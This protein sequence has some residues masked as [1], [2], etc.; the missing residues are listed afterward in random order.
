MVQELLQRCGIKGLLQTRLTREMAGTII[1]RS[2][3]KTE[4]H[5]IGEQGE[6]AAALGKE[7][8]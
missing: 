1:V 6:N 8:K 5:N 2:D 3:C 4:N 7:P